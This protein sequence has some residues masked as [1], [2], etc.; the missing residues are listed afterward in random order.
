MS[1]GAKNLLKILGFIAFCIL[2]G[3]AIYK[4]FFQSTPRTEIAPE[5]KPKE[6][7]Q[8][9]LPQSGEREIKEKPSI[10]EQIFK[11][12]EEKPK[13]EIKPSP[14]ANG[15]L[16]ETKTFIET[17]SSFPVLSRNGNDLQY[18]NQDDGKFYRINKDGVITPLS[19]KVFYNAKNVTWSPNKNKAIIEY[20]DNSKIIYKFDEKKQI[21]IPSHWEDFS[22]SP[23]DNG[24]V[25]KSLALDPSNRWL[26]VASEDG[27][28]ARPIEAIGDNADKVYPS[29]SPNRQIIALYTKG[30]DFDRQEVFFEGVNNE[31][32]KS[33]IVQGRGLQFNWSPNGDKLVYSAYSSDNYFK[34]SLWT[35]DTRMENLGNNRA[36]LDLNTWASKCSFG[37]TTEMYCA[38]PKELPEGAGL[39]P[40]LANT[41]DDTIYKVDIK[42]GNK[43]I[44]AIPESKTS[45]SNLVISQDGSSL[46]LTDNATNQIKQIKLK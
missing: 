39:T 36:K 6:V 16:T 1:Y 40:E 21:T 15:G 3:F 24:L 46:Y 41:T 34:P 17:P 25:F 4:V 13:P 11:P 45:F 29:W 35:V 10:I 18:Y 8:G 33:T 23:S 42:T 12:E 44:I 38:V 7:S 30:L 19:D 28:N 22:F 5:E 32:F 26:A 9:G 2:I 43:K 14:V 31:N 27:A 20:P 37:N